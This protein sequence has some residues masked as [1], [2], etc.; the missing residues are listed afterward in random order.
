MYVCICQAV[1][2][3]EVRE[4]VGTGACS[5]HELSDQLGVGQCCGRC[6]PHV[7]A[8]LQETLIQ[9]ADAGS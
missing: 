3:G 6:R 8:L 5:M 7:E 4:A 2:D 9:A 1:S